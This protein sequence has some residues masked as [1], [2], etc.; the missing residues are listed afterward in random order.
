M[1]SELSDLLDNPEYARI[2]DLVENYLFHYDE[3]LSSLA[4]QTETRDAQALTSLYNMLLVHEAH[5]P[6]NREQKK[7]YRNLR[8][9]KKIFFRT[10]N[11]LYEDVVSQF[12]QTIP[13][14]IQ[15]QNIFCDV[16]DDAEPLQQEPAQHQ[17]PEPFQHQ[18]PEQPQTIT[19]S[20]AALRFRN[21]IEGRYHQDMNQRYLAAS[22]IHLTKQD[23][24][25]LTSILDGIRSSYQ[26]GTICR[27]IETGKIDEENIKRL[28]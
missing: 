13:L 2:D 7:A 1:V 5:T 15:L 18:E 27:Y 23:R 10:M 11:N 24:Q 14:Y 28:F 16:V 25:S 9:F 8:R 12:P 6:K 4:R 19:L 21:T 17:G 22:S 20:P 26:S 3:H